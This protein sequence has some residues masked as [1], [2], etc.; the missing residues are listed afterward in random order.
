MTFS[1]FNLF[2]VQQKL[3]DRIIQQHNLEHVDLR[4]NLICALNVEL[5]ELANGT[6]CFKHWSVKEAS[7]KEVILEELVDVLHFLLEI[8]LSSYEE[9][10][11]VL[12][13]NVLLTAKESIKYDTLTEQ[14][15][16]MYTEIGMLNDSLFDN[17][18]S[19]NSID[20]SYNNLVGLFFGL[21]ELL[22]FTWEEVE[23]AY[24]EKNAINH[25]RQEQ[26]Y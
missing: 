2:P 11:A 12:P 16:S 6:R 18:Y 9:Y 8:G 23:A 1:I 15:N 22:E 5:A 20:D 26:G 10:G 4:P 19:A 24:Y 17:C 7:P 3:R 14:I 25:E 21:C 13:I